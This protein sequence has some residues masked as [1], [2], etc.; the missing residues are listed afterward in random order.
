MAEQFL[1]ENC[2]KIVEISEHSWSSLVKVSSL[3]IN[4][5]KINSLLKRIKHTEQK[6]I[7][8]FI[9]INLIH[10]YFTVIE[11]NSNSQN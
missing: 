3:H 1:D 11:K 8:K 6:K 2:V 10:I 5:S 7:K 9:Q 4:Q